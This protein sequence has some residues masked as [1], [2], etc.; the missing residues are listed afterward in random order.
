MTIEEFCRLHAGG[1]R[2]IQSVIQDWQVAEIS[3]LFDEACASGTPAAAKECIGEAMRSMAGD[4]VIVGDVISGGSLLDQV[5]PVLQEAFVKL[6]GAKADSL[7]EMRR[8][9]LSHLQSADGGYRLLDDRHVVGFVSKLKAQI[10]ENLFK[11]HLG[12]VASLATSRSQEGWDVAV[13]Q[14]DGVVQYVQV[15]LYGSASGVVRH[16]LEVQQK[17]IN[18]ELA[19]V[20]SEAVSKVFFAVPADIHP[21]VIRLAGKHEGLA[22]MVYDK[23]IPISA[24]DASHL[25]NQGLA[26]VG[27]RQLKH[28]FGE[29]ASGAAAAAALHAAVNGFLMYKESKEL[30]AAAADT[31]TD[32]VVSAAGIGVGLVAESV[33][34]TTLMSSVVGITARLFIGRLTRSRWNFAEF[35][36]KSLAETE[37]LMEQ[38]AGAGRIA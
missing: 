27:P 1:A 11:E 25:V 36:K 21:D 34:R 31:L 26:N 24:K 9:L 23:A 19:G 30:A 35:L 14:A 13:R 18:G 15:K 16:M 4:A 33:I 7:T 37:V 5:P 12:S 32:T 17:A 20:D 38:L 2:D 8:I 28:F 10:G 6:M 22:D 29:W 3:D